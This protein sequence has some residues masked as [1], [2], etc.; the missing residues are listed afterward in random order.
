MGGDLVAEQQFE[1]LSKMLAERGGTP[2][3]INP[4]MF[5]AE[6]RK[7]GLHEAMCDAL[8]GRLYSLA[9]AYLL[10]GV[11]TELRFTP[12][13]FG[14]ELRKLARQ[15]DQFLDTYRGL[16]PLTNIVLSIRDLKRT[17]AE[18]EQAKETEQAATILEE[19]S[20]A[21]AYFADEIPK[22]KRGTSVNILQERFITELAHI[23]ESANL[24]SIIIQKHTGKRIA[25][26][27]L[28]P[29]AQCLF[30]CIKLIDPH[31]SARKI[32]DALERFDMVQRPPDPRRKKK[33]RTGSS[34]PPSD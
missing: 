4:E 27:P 31:V 17:S 32:D 29:A 10:P 19:L 9:A 34:K 14:K 26:K 8:A 12:I 25:P 1:N 13:A 2:P 15:A 24:G 33:A 16:Y 18:I 20:A 5:Q 30:D 22:L 3:K 11:Y 21:A 6:L 23:I 7:F 28:S